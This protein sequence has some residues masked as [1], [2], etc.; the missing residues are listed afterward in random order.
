MLRNATDRYIALRRTLGYKLVKTERHLHAFSDFA[1]DRGETHIRAAT[2]LRWLETVAGTPNTRARRM[3][4]IILFARFLHAED[5]RH[6]IPRADLPRSQVRPVP[7]IYTPDEIARILDAAGSLRHQKPNPLRRQLYVMLFGLIAATGLRVCEA[8]GLKLDDIQPGGVLHIRET[9][10][11]KSRLVPLHATVVEALDR[12]LALRRQHAC[13]SPWLFT[14]VQ[15]R[16]MCPTTVNY[17]FRC[18]LRR[19]GIAPERR[20]QPRIHDLRHTFATRVLEQ[21][22]AE[23]RAVARHFVALSTYLGHVDVRNTYWYLEATPGLMADI[24]AAG[25]MLV[26]E[27]AA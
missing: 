22:G 23:R 19:A 24:A 25:E 8:L 1:A 7:Y 20:Q 27:S 15:H 16:E 11:R 26:G 14:S 10:F 12:Y 6:E 5:S 2:V 18:V 3:S 17:T 21:C 13:E 4:E 9:K